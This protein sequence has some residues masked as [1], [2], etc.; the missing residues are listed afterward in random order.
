MMRTDESN[1]GGKRDNEGALMA[2]MTKRVRGMK[3]DNI[4]P[5]DLARSGGAPDEEG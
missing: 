4:K 1:K 5:Q 3:A 2:T